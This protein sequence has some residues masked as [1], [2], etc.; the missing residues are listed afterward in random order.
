MA[1]IQVQFRVDPNV[2]KI[3]KEQ[4]NKGI[5][6]SEHDVARI[7]LYAYMKEKYEILDRFNPI[8]EI[9]HLK[10]RVEILEKQVHDGITLGRKSKD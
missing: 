10:S 9:A 7:F 2:F 5:G 3:L 8:E 1:K 4:K 6:E